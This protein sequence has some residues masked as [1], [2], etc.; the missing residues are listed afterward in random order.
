[1][2]L[3]LALDRDNWWALVKTV[4]NPQSFIK[5]EEFLEKVKT[6]ERLK[7]ESKNSALYFNLYNRH[8]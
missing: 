8:D 4:M 2:E 1:M 6:F 3:Y 5:G 7:C